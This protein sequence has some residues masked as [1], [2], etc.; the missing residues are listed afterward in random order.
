M[1]AGAAVR[2]SAAATTYSADAP[3]ATIGRKPTTASPTAT[4]STPSPSASTVPETSYPGVC[5]SVTGI[6][7]CM[8]PAR[9]FASTGL[10]VVA[11][12]RMRTSPAPG[13]GCSA[14]S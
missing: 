5:G 12:T 9:M 13:T 2:I 8:N 4:L 14:S 1:L 3:S 7:P 11:A 6:G 10:N